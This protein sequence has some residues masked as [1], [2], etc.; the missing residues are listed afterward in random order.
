MDFTVVV[1]GWLSFIFE[2]ANLSGVSAIRI[3]RVLRPLRSVSRVTGMKVLVLTL[4]SSL[5]KLLTVILLMFV[6]LFTFAITS[7]QLF[8]G[9]ALVLRVCGRHEHLVLCWI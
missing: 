2:S 1:A 7:V 5:P 9:V 6:L 3:L 4:I 8:K